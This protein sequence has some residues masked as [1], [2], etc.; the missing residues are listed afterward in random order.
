LDGVCLHDDLANRGA[1]QGGDSVFH[2]EAYGMGSHAGFDQLDRCDFELG[3]LGRGV[4]LGGG[5]G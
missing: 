5:D 4:G 2:A 1:L 3:P